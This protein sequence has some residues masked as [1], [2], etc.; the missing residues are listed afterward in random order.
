MAPL[1]G[2]L[3]RP[4]PGVETSALCPLFPSSSVSPARGG[5]CACLPPC[6]WKCHQPRGLVPVCHRVWGRGTHSPRLLE[7]LNPS[8]HSAP[9]QPRGRCQYET[10]Q[11]HR[12]PSGTREGGEGWERP[13][14][15]PCGPWTLLLSW[16]WPPLPP[17]APGSGAAGPPP[18]GL[19]SA[20]GAVA[21]VG[22]Q[23]HAHRPR[24]P[25][26]ALSS[27]HPRQLTR[28]PSPT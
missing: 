11:N 19:A 6:G 7:D 4:L 12:L 3:P 22:A 14:G 2:R 23:H 26:G 17:W 16:P 8:H 20:S 9:S 1:L 5:L 10:N 21:G 28:E 13:R 27:P 24:Q 18:A 25:P 15:C